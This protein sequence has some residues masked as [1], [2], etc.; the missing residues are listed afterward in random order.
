MP[1]LTPRAQEMLSLL[2][3]HASG[4]S[5]SQLAREAGIA[6][7]TLTW[8]RHRLR[9]ELVRPSLDFVELSLSEDDA[10]SACPGRR[11]AM[12]VAVG[13]FRIELEP[14]FAA[15]DLTRAIE[16]IRRC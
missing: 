13:D 9:D 11:P 15:A 1:K 5:L 6:P 7:A 12:T 2:R 4:A 10:L 14:G 8:W 3:R 16:V